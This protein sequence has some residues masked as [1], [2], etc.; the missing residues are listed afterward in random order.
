MS[1][2]PK[3]H[4]DARALTAFRV[5]PDGRGR[6]YTASVPARGWAGV[7][8]IIRMANACG[9]I[10]PSGYEQYYAILDVLSDPDTGEVIQDYVIP[11][12]PCNEAWRWWYRTLNLRVSY[13]DGDPID[14]AWR[15]WVTDGSV[16]A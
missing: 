16:V 13:T 5:L 7:D 4:P 9:L 15:H 12:M 3:L 8:R 11:V 1:E 6:N 2:L 10:R 14:P